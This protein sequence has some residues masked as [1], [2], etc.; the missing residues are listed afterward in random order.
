[1]ST[2]KYNNVASSKKDIKLGS[3]KPVYSEKEMWY[4]EVQKNNYVPPQKQAW[5]T[6][7]GDDTLEE[8]D[9]WY[10]GDRR[11]PMK[12]PNRSLVMDF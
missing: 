4:P 6:G 8:E 9:K 12:R 11:K 1:M 3:K 2:D 10:S 7:N 5:D